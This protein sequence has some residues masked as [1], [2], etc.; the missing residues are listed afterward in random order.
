MA[1]LPT[2]VLPRKFQRPAPAI[3][4]SPS[5]WK[6]PLAMARGRAE[7]DHHN[8]A[9]LTEEEAERRLE[10]YGP[11]VVAQERRY[12]GLRLLGTAL[13]NPLVILLLVLA[14]ALLPHR[15]L[16]GRRP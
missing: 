14:V 1:I 9:G 2:V 7:A 5:S 16:P 12:A 15:R 10:E 4:V 6:L 13:I 8:H 11:N 3:R